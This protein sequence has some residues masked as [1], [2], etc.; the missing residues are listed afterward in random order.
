MRTVER[1]Q[2]WG[3]LGHCVRAN[4]TRVFTG[5]QNI[6]DGIAILVVFTIL[7]TVLFIRLFAVVFQGGQ[8]RETISQ[9]QSG[10][11]R[12]GEPQSQ[13]FLDA[14]PVDDRFKCVLLASVE[15]QVV[16]QCMNLTIDANA[17][18]SLCPQ[19]C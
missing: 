10:L 19:L 1:K 4:R 12:L 13:I 7:F 14:K 15:F 3:K 8:N 2:A 17:Q 11:E 16:I 5:K 9:G 18:I 6:F